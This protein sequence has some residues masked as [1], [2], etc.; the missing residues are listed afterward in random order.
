MARHIFWILNKQI[1]LPSL[2]EEDEKL[3]KEAGKIAKVF[4][5]CY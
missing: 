1:R 2:D 5:P 4:I 3:I